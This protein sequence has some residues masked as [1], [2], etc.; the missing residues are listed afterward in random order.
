[1]SEQSR[2][3]TPEQRDA[4]A[5]SGSSLLV[6]AAAGSGKTSVLTERCVH[7]V[8]DAERRCHISQ[9]L[10]VTFTEAAA[11]EMRSRIE[12]ALR[13]RA[14]RTAD[15][16]HIRRQLALVEHASISTLH[17]FCNRLLRQHFHRLGLDP[18]FRVLDGDEA[19]LLRLE[20]VRELFTEHYDQEPTGEFERFIDA[21]GDGDD[22]RLMQQAVSVYELLR[23]LVDPTGWMKSAEG[24]ISDAMRNPLEESEL[25]REYLA[26]IRGGLEDLARDCQ[27]IRQSVARMGMQPYI[28]YVDYLLQIASEWARLLDERG[29]DALVR[30]ARELELQRLP[31]V[32]G[33]VAGKDIAMG[34]VRRAQEQFKKG[35]LIDGLRFSAAEWQQGLTSI[36]PHVRTFLGLLEEFGRRYRKQKDALRALDFSD[37][38]RYALMLLAEGRGGRLA[39]SPVSRLLHRQYQHVLVDE[40]QD[41][42]ELQDAILRLASRECIAS[43]HD[44]A[45]NLFCVGDVKQSIY[46]FRLA[47]PTLFLERDRRFRSG[48]SHGRVIDLQA[49]FRSR[50]PLLETINL[51][52]QRLMTRTA[53][54]I[55]YDQS[56]RLHPRAAFPPME[57]PRCF[58]GA[59]VEL[60]YLPAK[61][62]TPGDDEDDGELELERAEREAVLIAGRIHQLMGGDGHERMLVTD[63]GAEGRPVYR[64][65]EYRDMVILLRS[66]RY[67]AEEFADVLRQRGIPVH[68]SGGGGFFDSMEVRDILSLLKLLDNQRQDIPLAAVLRSPLASLPQPEDCLARIRVAYPRDVPFHEAVVR[69]ATEK[70]DD[71]AAKLRDLLGDLRRWR[72]MARQ[73]PIDELIWTLYEETGFRAFCSGLASG[74]QRCANLIHLHE[75]ARQF[76]RFSRQGLY[77]F[78]RFLE[79]LGQEVDTAPA[80]HLSEAEDVVRILSVHKS[81]GLEFPVV[82]LPELGKKI[83][84]GGCGGRIVADRRSGLGLVAIDQDKRIR[85]PSLASSLVSD[86]LRRAAMAEEMRILY[87]AMTRA[88]EH[89]IL[90]GTCAADSREMW[91]HKWADHAGVLPPDRVLGARSMLDWLGPVA[92]MIETSH[93]TAMRI[94]EHPPEE[95]QQWVS[96]NDGPNTDGGIPEALAALEPLR[97]PPAQ[98]AIA[99]RIIAHLTAAYP[100]GAFCSLEASR[101][102][103]D[104]AKPQKPEPAATAAD[105]KSDASVEVVALPRCMADAGAIAPTE[106]GLAAHILLQ[107]LDFSRPRSAAGPADQ[108]D[109]LVEL[110]ILSPAQAQTIDLASIE[111]M[112]ASEV[113]QLLRRAAGQVIRELP[114]GF[115][116][117]E[118]PSDDPL[119]QVMVRGRIDALIP[120]DRGFTLVDYKTDHISRQAVTQRAQAYRPQVAL[121]RHAIERITGRPVH[122][123]H[124]VFLTP[125]RIVTIQ[126]Q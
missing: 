1:M 90:V 121:Y 27:T 35:A 122:T 5:H 8:C 58:A 15:D 106:R 74:Q 25:G 10:V 68:N 51:V 77:R 83:N 100:H 13:E 30:A 59:P 26:V 9:L 28:H 84:L 88:R 12:T 37:L 115:A 29:Y 70:D 111:W 34:H 38:E 32:P 99:D 85:Y 112:L 40:Y 93:P 65:I 7:L 64:L 11:G 96:A 63:R 119:D 81:K 19:A 44:A 67:H 23:S 116:V 47:E 91:E 50:G 80:S 62:E 109:R 60:H 56:Q 33:S 57:G 14:R 118:V 105:E 125:R 114:L 72:E 89:L 76:G 53:V 3:W 98:D 4:I 43:R 95:I 66:M 94:H 126:G 107:H 52:F 79:N 103:T 102:V 117:A 101:T 73:R 42:N 69:Y 48:E 46:G 110:K 17:G 36:L 97:P 75:R 124:L 2:T 49:N 41:I 20:L 86:R 24:R 78:N 31:T 87:V 22:E 55:E 21:Y 6:S 61:L 108:L 104:L 71:L 54:D 39:P 92:A 123:A 16:V 113:G 82:I 120:D 18:G 45:P